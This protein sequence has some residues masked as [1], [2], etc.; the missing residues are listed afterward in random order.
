MADLHEMLNST[1][2]MYL[3]QGV[4]TCW[5]THKVIHLHL[6]NHWPLSDLLHLLAMSLL[7]HLQP[8]II[9]GVT[10]PPNTHSH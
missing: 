5:L 4:Q 1:G 3:K 7:H 10:T 2:T 8:P 6:G 9:Y